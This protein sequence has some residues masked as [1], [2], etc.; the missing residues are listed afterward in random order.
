MVFVV[1]SWNFG[2]TM[3]VWNELMGNYGTKSVE[4]AIKKLQV[5]AS[6]N[7]SNEAEH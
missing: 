1:D 2:A 6:A 3:S 4:K 5:R 7:G